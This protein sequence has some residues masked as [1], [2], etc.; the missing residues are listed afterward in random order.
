MFVLLDNN[1]FV[2]LEHSR[3]KARNRQRALDSFSSHPLTS[4]IVEVDSL[5][6]LKFAI[7]WGLNK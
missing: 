2:S 4:C 1:E 7:E 5:V 6:D 3:E